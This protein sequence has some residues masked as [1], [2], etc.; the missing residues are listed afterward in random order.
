MCRNALLTSKEQLDGFFRTFPGGE[1]VRR[2]SAE[3]VSHSSSSTPAAYEDEDFWVGP[4]GGL[5]PPVQSGDY[6]HPGGLDSLPVAPAVGELAVLVLGLHGVKGLASLG[7]L[8]GAPAVLQGRINIPECRGRLSRLVCRFSAFRMSGSGSCSASTGAIGRISHISY[9]GPRRLLEEFRAFFVQ[10]PRLWQ[11]RARCLDGHGEY[12]STC[13]LNSGPY[14]YKP[15]V[16][17]RLSVVCSWLF[18]E[19]GVVCSVDA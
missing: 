18:A 9:V 4:A 16:S 17:G 19:Y 15:R 14:F 5:R 10:V 11:S 8:L 13:L 3:L 7:S 2:S 6:W 1:K 12:C